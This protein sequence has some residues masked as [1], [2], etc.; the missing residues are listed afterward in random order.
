MFKLYKMRWNCG[1]WHR[2]APL[3]GFHGVLAGFL[4]AVKQLMPEQ[5]ITVLFVLKLR[6]KVT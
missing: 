6:A 2:Y 4:V 1:V 3:S 5:E